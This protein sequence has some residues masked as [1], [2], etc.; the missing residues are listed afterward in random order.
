[1]SSVFAPSVN[2]YFK[3]AQIGDAVEGR[4]TD[5]GEQRQSYKYD[6]RPNAPRQ[7]D[8]YESG[9]PKMEIPVTLQTELRDPEDADDD[10][11]RKLIIPVFF[12]DQSILAAIRDAVRQAGAQDL[13]VGGWLGVAFVGYDPESQNPQ[14][15]RKLYN[16]MYR[17][18]A[19]GGGA[20]SQGQDQAPAAQPQQQ[21]PAQLSTQQ[22]Q[23]QP[24][25]P[26]PQQQP[27]WQQPQ[28]PAQ[29]QQPRTAQDYM[30]AAA[31]GP[32]APQQPA[33]QQQWQ[34][35][36]AAPQQPAQAQ[37]AAPQQTWQ[38]P[39]AAPQQP[40]QVNVDADSVRALAAQ[41]FSDE[42]IAA[43]TGAS[44]EAIRTIRGLG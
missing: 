40:Q 16:A 21:Q 34:Q 42:D 5:I 28:A 29:Q 19:P 37:A 26:A 43:A 23:Q 13:D 24:Q 18:P 8:F 17:P 9:K 41:G 38:Q 15:P 3:F 2:R 1:M 7:H 30:Q 4:I 11:R 39:Q 6:P 27:Q 31:N 36:Q 25:Q 33:P 32:Q 44:P 35:P 14:N 22:W 10:G 20:F 12:K